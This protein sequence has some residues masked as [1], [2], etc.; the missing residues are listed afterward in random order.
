MLEEKISEIRLEKR[1]R[2]DTKVELDLSYVLP[3]SFF[4]SE[5]DKIHFYREIENIE[6]RDELDEIENDFYTHH[7]SDTS[8]A[9]NLFLLLRAR[10]IFKEF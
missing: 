7:S 10:I 2:I 8:N 4:Q 9:K 5:E 6:D 1:N 3:E